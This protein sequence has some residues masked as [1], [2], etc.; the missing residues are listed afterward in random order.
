ME[1]SYNV[2]VKDGRKILISTVCFGWN[3]VI[4]LLS[5][6]DGKVTKAKDPKIEVTVENPAVKDL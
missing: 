5:R 3:E 2:V 1:A 6:C 4:E